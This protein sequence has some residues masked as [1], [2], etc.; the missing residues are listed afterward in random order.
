MSRDDVGWLGITGMTT[1]MDKSLGTVVQFDRFLTHAKLYSR[2]TSTVRPYPLPTTAHNRQG[3]I[4][5]IFNIVLGGE[6][7]GDMDS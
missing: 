7:G 3:T 4:P 5:L 1:V 2:A 6:G